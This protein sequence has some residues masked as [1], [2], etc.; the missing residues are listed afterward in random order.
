MDQDTE[1]PLESLTDTTK[2][3]DNVTAYIDGIL[4]II[5][6]FASSKGYKLNKL[7]LYEDMTKLVLFQ[8]ELQNVRII[9]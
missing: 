8:V 1:N 5:L 4:H 7:L 2:E 6:A 9:K 3:S